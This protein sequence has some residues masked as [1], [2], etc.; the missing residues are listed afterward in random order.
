MIHWT[1]AVIITAFAFYM[2]KNGSITSADFCV[3]V[4]LAVC[5]G[6][7]LLVS[8]IKEKDEFEGLL[9]DEKEINPKKIRFEYAEGEITYRKEDRQRLL[10]S[11]EDRN[12]TVVK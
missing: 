6:I 11:I 2:G 5:A 4:G 3:F 12:P 1:T 10:D 8:G 9:P 7:Y